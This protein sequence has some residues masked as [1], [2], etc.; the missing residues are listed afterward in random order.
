MPQTYGPEVSVPVIQ[1]A[2]RLQGLQ[3][4]RALRAGGL[5]LYMR[6]GQAGEA[7]AECP[8]EPG[9]TDLGRQ[10]VAVVGAALRALAIP[11]SG[12]LASEA[13]RARD[14]ARGL[15]LGEPMIRPEIN[16][17]WL[18]GRPYRFEDKFPYLMERPAPGGNL[19]VVGH[20]QGAQDRQDSILIELAEVVV[21]QPQTDGR[22]LPV[23]RILPQDWKSL[24][25]ASV[26]P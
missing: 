21:Y 20:V 16:Q 10:Q 23:A 9:L 13:C 7:R 24:Q 17:T 8:Q 15:A 22:P 2:L 18:K 25:G 26:Q 14:S 12:L 6:H 5:I 19:M 1:P 11:V 3:L 4:L